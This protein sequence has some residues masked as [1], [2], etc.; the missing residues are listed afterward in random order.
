MFTFTPPLPFAN[1]QDNIFV[2]FAQDI[3]SY[4]DSLGLDPKNIFNIYLPFLFQENIFNLE[5]VPIKDVTTYDNYNKL[6][7]VISKDS[8]II[9]FFKLNN[10]LEKQTLN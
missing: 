8:F 4:S 6:I 3:L 7:D 9:S 2:C 10:F 5:N 1:I